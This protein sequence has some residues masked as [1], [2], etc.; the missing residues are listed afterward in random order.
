[1]AN[2]NSKNKNNKKNNTKKVENVKKVNNTEKKEVK[3]VT[4][5]EEAKVE[6][7]TEEVKVEKVKTEKVKKE[8]KTFK[9]SSKQRDIVLV[10]LAAVVLVIAVVLTG[11]KKPKLDIELPIALEGKAGFTEIKYSEYE[12][13]LKTEAPFVVVI[14][15]DGC[16]HC[17]NYKPIVK[18]VAD[19]YKLPI[20]Y[21]NLSNLTQDE[22][23]ALGN[24]NKYLK[25]GDWG[26]PTTLFMYGSTVVESIG[27]YVDETE[28]TEFVKE[29]FVVEG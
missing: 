10:L 16:G 3:K 17:D 29:N 9:L 6:K 26:T 13:K 5:K 2:K 22:Y 1:M 20:S 27:G 23:V 14:V 19:K 25:K 8:K 24:S 4:P 12:E 18:K 11:S 28:F 15:Q 21:I 7:V